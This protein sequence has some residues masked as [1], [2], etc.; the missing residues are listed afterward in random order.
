MNSGELSQATWG[1]AD[2]APWWLRSSALT[3]SSDYEANCYMAVLD[4]VSEDVVS[5]EVDACKHHSDAYY[6][7]L[8][9]KPIPKREYVPPPSCDPLLPTKAIVMNK[10]GKALE[11]G[12]GLK[13]KTGA[14]N[15]EWYLRKCS[16]TT[17]DEC[18]GKA[19]AWLDTTDA[20]TSGDVVAWTSKSSGRVYDCAHGACSQQAYPPP[21]GHWG[22]PYRIVGPKAAEGDEEDGSQICMGDAV[23]FY[24][25]QSTSWTKTHIISCTESGCTGSSSNA[26]SDTFTLEATDA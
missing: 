9:L 1:S 17:Y 13:D 15:Q 2:A 4:F 24:G 23:W 3:M 11:W 12:S 21:S 18:L 19:S 6:C 14:E 5:F 16:G 10:D 22:T 8:A 7:Q 26:Q 20:V 25:L